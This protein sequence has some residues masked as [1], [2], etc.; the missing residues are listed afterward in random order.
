VARDRKQGERLELSGTPSIFINGR[1]FE[2]AGEFK[3]DLEEWVTLE[4]KLSGG[5]ATPHVTEAAPSGPAPS[6][7]A[8]PTGSAKAAVKD[9][10]PRSPL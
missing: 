6:A 7:S 4:I 8:A 10:K 9:Q 3:E 1:K 2:S 5:N